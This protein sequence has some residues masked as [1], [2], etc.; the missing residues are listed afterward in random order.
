MGEP[1]DAEDDGDKDVEEDAAAGD[2]GDDG[3]V[4]RESVGDAA[5]AW[6]EKQTIQSL[7]R[8]VNN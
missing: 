2:D 4:N 7:K 3:D 6:S 1:G 8:V 5:A